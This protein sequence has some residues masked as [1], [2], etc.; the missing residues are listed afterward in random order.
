MQEDRIQKWCAFVLLALMV[1]I[2]LLG[3]RMSLA[4]TLY[5]GQWAQV[6]PAE[7]QWFRSQKSPKSGISCCS[8]A[9]G[10]YAEE[11]IRDGH[12]WVRY[13][14]HF[15][16]NGA[17][18]EMHTGWVEVPDDVVIRDANRHGAPVVWWVWETG[19][20]P[21]TAV[22]KIRCYAPGAGI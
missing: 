5:P 8:E 3:I 20:T 13:A 1:A 6:D 2:T 15:P 9:D 11:D 19:T 12:Y 22:T 4:R 7:R 18:Y 16:L 14:W 21:E 17:Q 10:T